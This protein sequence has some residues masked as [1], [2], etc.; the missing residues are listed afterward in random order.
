MQLPQEALLGDRWQLLS[1]IGEGAMGEVWHGRHAQLGHDVAIK[2]MKHEAAQDQNLVVRFRREAR[3]AAQLRSKYIV[4]VEDYGTS[5]DGR[6]YL[7]ME[8]LR[9]QTLASVLEKTPKPDRAFI[10]RVV[11]HIAAA[12]DVAHPAGIVHRDLKPENCFVVRDDDGSALVKVLDFGVAKVTDNVFVTQ[13][14][15]VT[16]SHALLGTPVY[17]SPEQARGEPD[18]DGRSDLWSLSVIAY[19]M[20]TGRIPFDVGSLAQVLYA[21]LAGNIPPPSSMD[22]T[23]PRSVDGWAQRALNR[24]RAQRFSTGRELAAALAH[25]L[26]FARVTPNDLHWSP[27][28]GPLAID[29]THIATGAEQPGSY[30]HYAPVSHAPPTHG[31]PTPSYAP[32][33]MPSAAPAPSEALTWSGPGAGA[34]LVQQSFNGVST[35]PPAPLPAV[36]VP[37]PNA[38]PMAYATN[39]QGNP[40]AT[41]APAYAPTVTRR[42]PH[43]MGFVFLAVGVL[44]AAA[45]GSVVR[46]RRAASRSQESP[47]VATMPTPTPLPAT[48]AHIEP[49]PSPGATSNNN[50]LHAPT[51]APTNATASA[52]AGVAHGTTVSGASRATGGRVT[53]AVTHTNSSLAAG[54][55]GIAGSAGLA[56]R[57]EQ[58][59]SVA[60]STS[61]N[62]NGPSQTGA[63]ERRATSGERSFDE[64]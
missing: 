51:N 1:P 47:I 37:A 16:G 62:V 41:L 4:R 19:E 27:S 52:R 25:S 57:Q 14:G 26:G 40:H 3:I 42:R 17:M 12:C 28:S 20:L 15:V 36:V 46:A 38:H 48:P 63:G 29:R 24:D 13:S 54:S 59:A 39:A 32:L 9:G 45:L 23:L 53:T 18:I 49:T 21:V 44:S 6:P 8:F 56:A 55:A 34:P 30:G 7:V 2:L 5:R 10:A 11:Q 22:P 64:L 33:H 35:P 58:D 61:A 50:E 31:S 43:G 60:A